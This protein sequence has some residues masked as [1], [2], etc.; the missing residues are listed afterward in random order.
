MVDLFQGQLRSVVTCTSCGHQSTRFDPYMWLTLPLPPSRRAPVGCLPC[1]SKGALE[2]EGD[3]ELSDCIREFCKEESLS[4][5]NVWTCPNCKEPK[6]VRGLDGRGRVW[7][8][9][10]ACRRSTILASPL[11]IRSVR[12]GA[13]KRLSVHKLPPFLIIHLKRYSSARTNARHIKRDDPV[14]FPATGLDLSDAVSS[15]QTV[16]PVYS[17][18]AVVRHQGSMSYGHYTALVFRNGSWYECNDD[19]VR[20]V[21]STLVNSLQGSRSAYLLFY[22]RD[23]PTPADDP[24]SMGPPVVVPPASATA[25][26]TP[27]PRPRRGPGAHVARQSLSWPQEW[28]FKMDAI[29]QKFKGGT[30]AAD[31]EDEEEEDASGARAV[32][33]TQPATGVEL[34]TMASSGAPPVGL[35][36]G[37]E[38]KGAAATAAAPTHLPNDPAAGE[39]AFVA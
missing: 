9:P 22:A 6:C 17:L 2:E 10:K 31:D 4:E 36:G 12:R 33:T 8:W 24:P 34:V 20:Q 11:A 3:I 27:E 13:V 21:A 39:S 7:R 32:A 18:Y 37:S 29:P 1:G 35:R 16:A 23:A 15:P 14:R 38:K 26:A 19:N 5:D 28:P 30:G 25:E